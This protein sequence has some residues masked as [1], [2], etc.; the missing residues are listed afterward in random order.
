MRIDVDPHW[1]GPARVP[2]WAAERFFGAAIHTVEDD[3]HVG[4][5]ARDHARRQLVP[6]MDGV[7][8]RLQDQLAPSPHRPATVGASRVSRVRH[9]EPTRRREGFGEPPRVRPVEW[10]LAGRVG[11]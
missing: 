3:W 7:T 9:V 1:V 6:A 4:C 10:V 8:R 11:Q 5:F 2:A